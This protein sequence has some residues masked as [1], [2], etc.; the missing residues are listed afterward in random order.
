MHLRTSKTYS[1]CSHSS[2]LA[3]ISYQELIIEFGRD[4][5]TAANHGAYNCFIISTDSLPQHRLWVQMA[6]AKANGVRSVTIC[7]EMRLLQM[8]GPVLPQT[9][10]CKVH[11][12]ASFSG[13]CQ[14]PFGLVLGLGSWSC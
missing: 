11:F 10:V 13:H 14:L 4:T 2:A 9:R 12:E 8:A 3:Q 1:R 5:S 7:E 6:K